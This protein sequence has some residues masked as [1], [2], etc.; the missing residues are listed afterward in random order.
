MYKIFFN[1]DLFHF[2]PNLWYY[3][4]CEYILGEQGEME[5]SLSV[6]TENRTDGG[7]NY[8][9]NIIGAITS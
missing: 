6:F 2:Y 5:T 1:C 8:F 3:C 7:F 9:T 4:I